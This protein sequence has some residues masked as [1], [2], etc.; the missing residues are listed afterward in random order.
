MYLFSDNNSLR[1]L[2]VVAIMTAKYK[3]R[4]LE[5]QNA[6]LIA[7]K[8]LLKMTIKGKKIC[9]KRVEKANC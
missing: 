1:A 9:K 5:L 6:Q 4:I 7:N 2:E 8:S 3:K